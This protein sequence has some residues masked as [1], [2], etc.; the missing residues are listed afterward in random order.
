MKISGKEIAE[1]IKSELKV[2]IEKLKERGIV[3]KI[4]I[5]TLGDESSWAAYVR[6]KIKVAGELE[7]KAVLIPLS[8]AN[9][10]TLLRKIEKINKDPTF[11]GMIVQRPMPKSFNKQTITNAI[12][13]EKDI[14]GFSPNSK[15]GVP[16]WLAVKDLI[17]RSLK[18]TGSNKKIGEL[19]FAVLGKGETAGMPTING[20]R[21]LGAEP[22]VIDTKTQNREEILKNADVVIS[23]AGKKNAL[24]AQE[25]KP[26]AIVIGIGTHDE[27]GKIRGDYN[28]EEIEKVTGAYTP[29]PGGVGPVNLSYL[30]SNLIEAT[31]IQNPQ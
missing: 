25:I 20:L 5:I 30:F 17:E 12:A 4:A 18:E 31:A 24:N 14:D 2:R 29:T 19:R 23:C 10:Q 1:E 15:F 22:Q 16:V 28:E 13:P 21:K 7:I 6:Q 3:P 27:N 9:E 11:H 26:G 8:N